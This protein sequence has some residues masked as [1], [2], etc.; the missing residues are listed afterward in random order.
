MSIQQF[1]R[2]LWARRSIL[3]ITVGAALLA[4]LLTLVLIPKS[5]E[6]TSRVVLEIIKPD[7]VTGEMLQSG[8]ARAYTAT[9]MEL[10]KDYRVAGR[11]VDK[12]GWTGSPEL[13]QQYAESGSDLPFHRWLANFII[14]RLDVRLIAGSNIME[15]AYNGTDPESSA[16]IAN[17]VRQAYFD[18]TLQGKQQEARKNAEWFEKQTDEVKAKLAVAEDRK[19]SFEKANDIILSEDNTD[20]DARTLEAAAGNAAI[21]Q[22][23][24]ISAPVISPSQAQL[25]Q[26]DATIAT[27]GRD[28]GPNHPQMIALRQQRAALAA[29]AGRELAAG[30]ATGG[31]GPDP[32]ATLNRQRQKVLGQRDKIAAAKQLQNDVTVLSEQLKTTS[33]K[34]AQFK[35]ESLSQEAGLSMLGSATPPTSATFPKTIPVLFGSLALGLGVGILLALL[36]E[37]LNRRVR[38]VDDLALLHLPVL[39][40]MVPHQSPQQ[41]RLLG[42]IPALPGPKN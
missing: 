22:M 24:V 10:I 40:A 21:P 38:G 30:R 39:G 32:V 5:Y 6:A 33:A 2:I 28:F 8:Y 36:V 1:F 29:Q 9:Q 12:L 7:P 35:Q 23:P 17:E 15:I 37:L 41:R 42:F 27:A 4:A 31:G 26:L 3:G 18:Q 14:D 20:V 11:A 16:V 34:A 19:A 13:A 25:A